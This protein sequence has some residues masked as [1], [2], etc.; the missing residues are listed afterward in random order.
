M[1]LDV[2]GVRR[3]GRVEDRMELYEPIFRD[4]QGITS[5]VGDINKLQEELQSL[6]ES[7]IETKEKLVTVLK[8]Q[9]WVYDNVEARLKTLEDSLNS[10]KLKG[11]DFLLRL[12]PWVIAIGVTLWTVLKG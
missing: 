3:L 8:N 4:L 12:I 6:R 5:V 7:R 1:D 10:F 2:E 9:D 11:W